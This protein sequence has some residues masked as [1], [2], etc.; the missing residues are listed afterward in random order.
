MGIAMDRTLTSV[1][2]GVLD[3]VLEWWD[4]K[5]GRTESFKTYKD[6]GR[7]VVAGIGYGLQV[8]MPKQA[9]LG[10]TLALSAT[11]LLVKSI[12]KPIRSAMKTSKQ[13]QE[14]VREQVF[15]PKRRVLLTPPA[16][17]AAYVAPEES[18]QLV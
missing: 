3:E 6:I 15:V 2:V 18:Y 12:A 8:F 1:G 10:E 7:L 9:R 16:P 14:Q 5:A 4:E 11:P 17:P 13:A